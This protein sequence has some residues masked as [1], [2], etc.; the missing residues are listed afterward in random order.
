MIG[1]L[2]GIDE[3]V[4]TSCNPI[5]S[6]VGDELPSGLFLKNRA[7]TSFPITVW[8]SQDAT[9]VRPGCKYRSN[10]RTLLSVEE[11]RG[12]LKSGR[13]WYRRLAYCTMRISLLLITGTSS[14][15]CGIGVMLKLSVVSLFSCF[16][17]EVT[18]RGGRPRISRGQ[19]RR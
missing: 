8:P 13:H 18:T 14:L 19:E 10:L 15:S 9:L 1:G 17:S 12:W 6:I 3:P 7:G 4:A 2:G 5:I 11:G 16:K